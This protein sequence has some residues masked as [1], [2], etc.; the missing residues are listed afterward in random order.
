MEYTL[1]EHRHRFAVW[2]AARSVQRSWT[3]TLLIS[4]AICSTSLYE[5]V[6]SYKA[7][8][9]QNDFDKMHKKWCEQMINK[10][11]SL[12]VMAS[13]GRVAKIIAVY[14]KTS[15]II[16]ANEGDNI[17]SIIHPPIDR[18]LL[19]NLP[20]NV[21]EFKSIRVLNWTQLDSKSY[22]FIVDTIREKLGAFDWR[23]EIL[24][25]PELDK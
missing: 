15:I 10:F 3:T 18:I 6:N 20:V 17:L 8:L 12:G 22:W 14:L 11:Q 2:T 23:L 7:I 25:R 13:Y 4:Q 5:F 24:W 16:R 9:K 19:R 1:S 21:K